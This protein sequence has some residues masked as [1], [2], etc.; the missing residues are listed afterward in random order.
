[1]RVVQIEQRVVHRDVGQR[2]GR[3]ELG[4]VEQMLTDEAVG[5]L[6][7]KNPLIHALDVL[8]AD[9]INLHI[10]AV[11]VE[12]KAAR[13]VPEILDKTRAHLLG[14]RAPHLRLAVIQPL[15]NLREGA[16]LG[17]IVGHEFSR[18]ERQLAHAAG[19]G[20]TVPRAVFNRADAVHQIA[21]VVVVAGVPHAP[22]LETAVAVAVPAAPQI[23]VK[24]AQRRV[25][26]LEIAAVAADVPGHAQ[27]GHG[28]KVAL[29]PVEMRAQAIPRRG[30]ADHAG[31]ATVAALV[32]HKDE[33]V[34]EARIHVAL[35]IHLAAHGLRLEPHA[36][37]FRALL[38]D[39]PRAK[40]LHILLFKRLAAVEHA[41]ICLIVALKRH[42]CG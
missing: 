19:R 29:H 33:Y 23:G 34:V 40:G 7:R 18:L 11:A 22:G 6:L 15:R 5:H 25:K 2:H 17:V 28:E 36:V 41:L 32:F 13:V 37:V 21:R 27:R 24:I 10:V 16:A 35:Y 8:K 12:R 31:Q 3:P 9:R 26:P 1:M 42:L 14:L 20:F 39:A 38:N 4:G 30:I